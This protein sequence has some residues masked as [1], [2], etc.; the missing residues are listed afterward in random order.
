MSLKPITDE[1]KQR[2]QE[3]V[4]RCYQSNGQQ[5]PCFS[6]TADDR[7]FILQCWYTHYAVAGVDLDYIVEQRMTCQ[8]RQNDILRKLKN[9]LDEQP[10]A[11][12]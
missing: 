6:R 5:V 4:N 7:L 9:L 2:L 8:N 1:K 10:K 11:S 12:E 3:A